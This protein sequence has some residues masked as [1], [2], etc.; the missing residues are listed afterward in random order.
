MHDYALPDAEDEKR[1]PEYADVVDEVR[2]FLEGQAE[3]CQKAG[4]WP[5]HIVID[6]G[7]GFGK[8]QTHN[9]ALLKHLRTFVEA[10]YAVLLGASRKRFMGDICKAS[11]PT[12]LV[13]ATTALGVAAGV[14]I[15][16]AHDVKE[17]RQAADVAWA[18]ANCSA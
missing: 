8:T 18:M 12:D 13:G 16:R 11:T 4:M 15:F 7:I 2:R 6:P 1:Q 10:G 9:L 14:R 3:D 5:H 17:N